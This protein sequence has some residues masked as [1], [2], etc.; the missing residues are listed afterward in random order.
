M[1]IGRVT[2]CDDCGA[3]YTPHARDCAHAREL[4]PMDFELKPVPFVWTVISSA[5]R[6]PTAGDFHNMKADERTLRQIESAIGEWKHIAM[7]SHPESAELVEATRNVAEL[8]S[9]HG[10]FHLTRWSL[11]ALD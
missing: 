3:A 1:K 6:P 9:L 5:S 10:C 2:V 4:A 11:P 7:E 8:V